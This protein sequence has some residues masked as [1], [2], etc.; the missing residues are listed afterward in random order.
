MRLRKGGRDVRTETA[1]CFLIR[2]KKDHSIM[3]A[4]IRDLNARIKYGELSLSL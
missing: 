2:D 1:A 3:I 4:D